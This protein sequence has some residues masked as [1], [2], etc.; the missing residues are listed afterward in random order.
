MVARDKKKQQG[1]SL[2]EIMLVVGI[3]SVL[4]FLAIP[5]FTAT[6]EKAIAATKINDVRV[7]TNMIEIYG[8]S[9][10]QYPGF[11][12]STG[13]PADAVDY[14][15]AAWTGDNYTWWVLTFGNDTYAVVWNMGLS[16]RQKLL[17]DSALDD[18]NL[19]TGQV[20]IDA[21]STLVYRFR[22]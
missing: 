13:L 19:G 3:M 22:Q 21:G 16:T 8:M 7:F 10:G 9:T 6:R 17:V 18:G 2:I 11:W 15:P 1:F 5:S 20:T 12:I 4:S 14:L